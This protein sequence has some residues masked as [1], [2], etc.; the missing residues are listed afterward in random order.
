MPNDSTVIGKYQFSES[1]QK[2]F[3]RLSGDLI[4]MH[5]DAVAAR[6]LV[7]CKAVVHGIHTLMCILKALPTVAGAPQTSKTVDGEL[8]PQTR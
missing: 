2:R 1:D 7:S 6:R 4:P 8:S 3:G 5:M